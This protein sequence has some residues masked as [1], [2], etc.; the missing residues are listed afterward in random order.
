VTGIR[1]LE[2][3]GV[4]YSLSQ[5]W[6]FKSTT[7]ACGAVSLR[8]GGE[9]MKWQCCE[10]GEFG[11]PVIH[12]EKELTHQFAFCIHCNRRTWQRAVYDKVESGI[13]MRINGVDFDYRASLLTKE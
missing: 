6:K 11:S 12:Y 2:S 7:T 1:R 3:N 13:A 8:E 4:G 5:A 10:C 9:A